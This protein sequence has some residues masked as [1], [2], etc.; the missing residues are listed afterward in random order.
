MKKIFIVH[1]WTYSTDKWSEVV[2]SLQAHGHEVNVL[3]VPGLTEGTDKAW[4]LDEYTEWLKGKL[5]QTDNPILIGHSNGGRIAL[6]FATQ[7]PQALERLILVDSGGIYHN[8]LPLRVKR[9]VF[10]AAAK[11][12][13]K[14]TSSPKL[15]N[16]LYRLAHESDYK[17]AT[18]HMRQTMTNLISVDLTPQLKNIHIPTLIIWGE[19]DRSTPV[20]DAHLMHQ[21]IPNSRLYILPEA[22]HSPHATHPKE[23]A[24]EILKEIDV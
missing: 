2:K 19:Q 1:G 13:K 18:P 15:R 14:I 5:E 24:S 3:T 7:H 8:E 22:G 6:S 4:T 12:G 17:N 23:V 16:L 10:G 9:L 21:S 11:V 20:S